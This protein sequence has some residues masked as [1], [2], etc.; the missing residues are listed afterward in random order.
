MLATPHAECEM[1]YGYE[2]WLAHTLI[3]T[4]QKDDE[5]AKEEDRQGEE[6]K[7]EGSEAEDK[8]VPA[9]P[10]PVKKKSGKDV[11][12]AAGVVTILRKCACEALA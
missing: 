7:A 10:P 1:A 2:T 9:P 8:A 11:S 6:Q 5:E 4:P 3:F 12:K